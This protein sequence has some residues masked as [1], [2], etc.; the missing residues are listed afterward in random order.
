MI[1]FRGNISKNKAN[2]QF[3]SLLRLTIQNNKNQHQHPVPFRSDF[4]G[5]FVE[6]YF[7]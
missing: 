2:D 1:F 5:Q 3:W 4:C 6:N 7:D